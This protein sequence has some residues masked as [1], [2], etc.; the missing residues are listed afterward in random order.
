VLTKTISPARISG[1]AFSRS[2]GS[3]SSH[4]F[5][6]IETTTPVP[7]KRSSARS[8]IASVPGNRWIGAFTWV[9]V[10]KMVEIL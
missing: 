2:S 4:F 10:W 5:F 7:K 1:E 6:G 8:P 3:M 9:E